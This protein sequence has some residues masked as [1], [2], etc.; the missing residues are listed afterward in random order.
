M[1]EILPLSGLF[2]NKDKIKSFSSVISPPYDVIPKLF[3]KR[4]YGLDPYNV[5][6]LILPRGRVSEKYKNAQKILQKWT[7]DK[8][9]IFDDMKC[10][11]AF[12]ENFSADDKRKNITGFV[13]LTKIEPYNSLNIIPH[14]KTQ[15]K[16]KK[17]RLN[18]L[19]SCRTNF[20][21]VYTLYK[22]P[23]KGI[24]EIL[25]KAM[26]KKPF[27][28][29]AAG[30][31]PSLSFKIWRISQMQYIKKLIEIMKDKRLIIADG[32]HRYET[33]LI[34]KQKNAGSII[35]ED[36]K[37][38]ERPQDYIL[39]LYIESSSKDI[40]VHP[41]H[42]LIKFKNPPGIENI[43]KKIKKDFNIEAVTSD[44]PGYIKKRLLESKSKGIKSFFIYSR[45]EKLYFLTL[46]SRQVLTGSNLKNKDIEYLNIDINILKKLLVERLN[47]HFEIKKISYT[48]YIRN[49]INKID[50]KKFD[51]GIFLNALTVKEIEKISFNGNILPDKS[52][53]FYPK[54]CTGL[55]MYKFDRQ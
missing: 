45:P 11:Y 42:R 2:Y 31:D 49:A 43:I 10:F 13:G 4:L 8:I 52:T 35:N 23:Q 18:L 51:L 3:K 37:N 30:Y 55:I 25:A 29:V 27:I 40:F 54:P 36:G 22:D 50:N 21:F 20:G 17:D 7:D 28:K 14:E 12:K 9:L 48:H 5:I 53:Y 1:V 16:P 24:M 26:Q 19:K 6:N 41:N 39:T 47:R 32:H 44:S 34:Y 33:S 15:S 46:R 38:T